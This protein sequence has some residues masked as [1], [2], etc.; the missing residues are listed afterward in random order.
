M[1]T[2]EQDRPLTAG[3]LL[4]GSAAAP[5]KPLTSPIMSAGQMKSLGQGLGHLPR[6][7]REAA[8]R[9]A[10]AAAA[11]LL[12]MD[13]I[14]MLVARGGGGRGGRRGA[15]GGYRVCRVG[16]PRAG[17]GAAWGNPPPRPAP[18]GPPWPR[19]PRPRAS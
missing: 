5:P 11:G 19:P 15:A 10:A 17:G 13:L 18:G 8:A 9:E 6:V 7:T 4:L 12:K 2:D 16:S 14:E 1:T 3:Y